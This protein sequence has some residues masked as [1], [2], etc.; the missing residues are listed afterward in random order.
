MPHSSKLFV[1]SLGGSLIAP[2][3]VDGLYVS[4]F[5]EFIQAQARTGNR[6]IIVTGGGAVC[7]QYLDALR[8]FKTVA[9]DDLAWLGIRVTRLNA[10]LLQ[11]AFGSSA[12]PKVIENPNRKFPFKQ[13]VVVA[14]GWLPG[15][16]TDDVAVRLAASFGV[17]TVLNLTNVDYVHTKDPNK[18]KDA[19]VIERMNWDE[20]RH[21]LDFDWG[22]G[23]H[24]PFDPVA[25]AL[26][27]KKHITVQILNGTNFKNLNNVLVG[28]KFKG[29][30]ISSK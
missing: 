28:K 14:G 13:K 2:D 19:K 26:A 16:S 23:F 17:T 10:L 1:L 29:T 18:F 12:Y 4:K 24:T 22:P 8:Q 25:A 27:Q 3:R 9:T 7:R 15:R 21:L 20:Y 5:V 6:F 11:K 30:I